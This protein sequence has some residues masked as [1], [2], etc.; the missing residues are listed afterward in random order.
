MLK[1]KKIVPKIE[2]KKCG[3]GTITY[4]DCVSTLEQEINAFL[5]DEKITRA[6]L[7]DIKYLED[8]A[9]IICDVQ[10]TP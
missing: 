9:L 4:D 3:I 5:S 7:I 8:S 1:V 10:E 6:E 2:K